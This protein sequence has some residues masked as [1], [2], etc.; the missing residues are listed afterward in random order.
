MK[1]GLILFV[2]AVL[3]LFCWAPN[4]LATL[5]PTPE[6]FVNDFANVLSENTEAYILEHSASLMQ[7]NTG[8]NC[9]SNSY[10]FRRP[11]SRRICLRDWANLGYWRCRRDNGLLILLAPNDGEIR[12]E[13][14]YGLEGALNDAKVGRYI[15]T[16][17]L[18]AY[19]ADDFDAGTLELYKAL[20]S[21]VMVEYHLEALPGYEPLSDSSPNEIDGG[22]C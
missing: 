19:K 15:D 20:L 8:S 6:F 22:S 13:V 10:Q 2:T 14:G 21:E 16:Y 4:A 1:R 18:D 9:R 11:Y 17:A 3:F 12:V 7:E 5:E